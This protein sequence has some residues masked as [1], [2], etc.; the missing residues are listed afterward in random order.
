MTST[1]RPASPTDGA[2]DDVPR[3]SSRFPGAT[4]QHQHKLPHL[5]I[6]PL[7][8]T[9]KRY[10]SALEPLQSADEHEQTQK[11]AKDFL[12]ND[13]PILHERLKEYASTRDSYIEEWWTESYLSHADSVVLNL[14][15]FF[16]LE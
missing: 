16:I 12:E 13:G 1:P 10:V 6:P 15:P 8:E 9:I 2:K 5:P 7:E 4:Y 14:N 11:V 3:S